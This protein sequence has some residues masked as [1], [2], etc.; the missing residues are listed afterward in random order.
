MEKGKRSNVSLWAMIDDDDDNKVIKEGEN[1]ECNKSTVAKGKGGRPCTYLRAEIKEPNNKKGLWT[2]TGHQRPRAQDGFLCAP[3]TPRNYFADDSTEYFSHDFLNESPEDFYEKTTGFGSQ[4]RSKD[5]EEDGIQTS[6][7]FQNHP[8]SFLNE[9]VGR[10]EKIF[11]SKS[12]PWTAFVQKNSDPSMAALEDEHR[13]FDSPQAAVAAICNRLVNDENVYRFNENRD[14][15]RDENRG[16]NCCENGCENGCEK[17]GGENEEEEEEKQKKSEQAWV[18]NISPGDYR[19][20]GDL[21][22]VDGIQLCGSGA[23]PG[24]AVTL[25]RVIIRTRGSGSRRSAKMCDVTICSNLLPA[26]DIIGPPFPQNSQSFGETLFEDEKRSEKTGKNP[27][28]PKNDS[29]AFFLKRDMVVLENLVVMFRV[30]NGSCEQFDTKIEPSA[31]AEP[32]AT[33]RVSGFVSLDLRNT[34]VTMDLRPPVFSRESAPVHEKTP[35]VVLFVEED[36]FGVNPAKNPNCDDVC[37]DSD[38]DDEYNGKKERKEGKEGKEKK[39]GKENYFLDCGLLFDNNSEGRVHGCT[40]ILDIP[41]STDAGATVAAIDKTKVQIGGGTS[42]TM[43]MHGR[44]AHEAVILLAVD[45]IID[46][47]ALSATSQ[48]PFSLLDCFEKNEKNEKNGKNGKNEKRGTVVYAL[49]AGMGKIL[50]SASVW[51]ADLFSMSPDQVLLAD[52]RRATPFDQGDEMPGLVGTATNFGVFGADE[53]NND[54]NAAAKR[55]MGSDRTPRIQLQ[56]GTAAGLRIGGHD[57]VP[58]IAQSCVGQVSYTC[59]SSSGSIQISGGINFRARAV[60]AE[61][62]VLRPS[63]T[64][65]VFFRQ[66]RPQLGS[67]SWQVLDRLK[68]R[69]KQMIKKGSLNNRVVQTMWLPDPREADK[70]EIYRGTYA[71]LV[72]RNPDKNVV[73]RSAQGAILGGDIIIEPLFAA[74]LHVIPMTADDESIESACKFDESDHLIWAVISYTTVSTPIAPPL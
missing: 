33:I 69:E 62:S 59:S 71:K 52:A 54:N 60:G 31:I 37:S 61:S 5:F 14:E 6:I 23:S 50:S 27:F 67:E 73:V 19:S 68:L 22:L 40:I 29:S 13:P 46:V 32:R 41:S 10:H 30:D 53:Y 56:T 57:A 15:N 12:V 35:L 63:D 26:I 74:S 18:I 1:D 58:R 9:C 43:R 64:V 28:F 38:N 48:G 65:V 25:G 24:G 47:V 44:L 34:F 16:E 11:L 70:R 2:E 49:V 17:N 42:L 20:D 66:P 51:R 4:T 72:N 39:E 8:P 7:I 3:Q 36:C 55:I 21:I 45:A